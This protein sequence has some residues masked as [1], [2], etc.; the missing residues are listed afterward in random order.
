MSRS[1]DQD[2]SPGGLVPHLSS[3]LCLLLLLA[4]VTPTLKACVVRHSVNG[5]S[6]ACH[7]PAQPPSH[8]PA[9]TLFLAVE[10]F[11]LTQLPADT[12][13]NISRLQELH[14][15]SNRLE[16]LAA[17][18]LL[19][20]PQ[21][22]V[23]DLTGNALA[24]LPPGLFRASCV[25]H[26]L[27]LKENQLR[28]LKAEWLSG[29]KALAYLDL[30]GNRLRTLPPRLLA[31]FTALLILD[32]SHNQLESLP[33]DLLQGPLRLERLHLEGNR[34]KALHKELLAPQPGLHYLFM[35]NNS[36]AMVAAGAF[37]GLRELDMLDLSDNLLSSVPAGLWASLG[38]PGR[39]MKEGFDISQNPWVCDQNL[40]DLY[41]WLVANNDTMFSRKDTLCAGPE[42]LKGRLLLEV[43]RGQDG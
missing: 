30:S 19:P 17:D 41:Y 25:L 26:T 2:Q 7:P 23:L 13:Q 14:L 34:L 8:F 16:M 24:G 39:A 37:E 6:V 21:L 12:L 22:Q 20:V 10:F 43:A 5:S 1:R 33:D 40:D 38:R 15:S 42:A 4:A 27:V 36:L 32:L 3:A 11:N 29:L 35:Q 31:N 9:D 18:F 28:D